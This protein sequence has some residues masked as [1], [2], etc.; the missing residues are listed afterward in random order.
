MAVVI[1]VCTPERK[2]T[3]GRDRKLRRFKVL[4]SERPLQI[5]ENRI[6]S[7]SQSYFQGQ[8]TPQE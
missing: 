6:C 4:G 7:L 5:T 2:I 3:I 8:I 1:L